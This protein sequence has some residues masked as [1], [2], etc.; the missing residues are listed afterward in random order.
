MS[1]LSSCH[2]TL[3]FTRP[4][5]LQSW[6]KGGMLNRELAL[7]LRLCEKVN[8]ITLITYGDHK[9]LEIQKQYPNLKVICNRWGLSEKHYINYLT[10]VL[11]YFMPK[12]AIFKSNQVLGSEVGLIAARRAG[13]KYV[14]RCGNLR[15]LHAAREHGVESPQ[16]IHARKIED[17]VF[18]LA[19][20]IV[21]PTVEIV[22][23]IQKS[24]GIS[25]E[26]VAIIPNYVDTAL[27]SPGKDKPLRSK[28]HLCSIGRLERQKN[29]L[30][31]LSALIGLDISLTIVGNGSLRNEL[32]DFAK[33]NQL[34]VDFIGTVPHN[35]LPSLINEADI[36]I[37]PSLYEGH[38][39]TIIEAMA[40]GS[41]IIT[42]NSPG[43]RE[44]VTHKENGYLCDTSSESIR[45]GIQK[46]LSYPSLRQKLGQ[47]ARAFAVDNFSL[48]HVVDLELS[49]FED[50]SRDL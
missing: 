36:Y 8:S 41:P 35:S 42:T 18:P 13:A 50:L 33:T 11:P 6:L 30:S 16:A 34:D 32:Q 17:E 43:I 5:S 49:V 39:K 31:L 23:V 10:K 25:K 2:L 27:F 15:S 3:F 26:K 45:E 12:P 7:Y 4:F 44:L 21:V 14:A 38:P 46:L 28:P 37:Q 9:D 29:M 40:C 19:D 48:D 1:D 24:Y 22:D 47:K 20:K